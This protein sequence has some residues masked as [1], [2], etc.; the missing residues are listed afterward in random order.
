MMCLS[1]SE[2]IL[3]IQDHDPEALSSLQGRLQTKRFPPNFRNR[4]LSTESADCSWLQFIGCFNRIPRKKE[5]CLGRK[6]LCLGTKKPKEGVHRYVEA[7]GA[8][9][10]RC[11][12]D[13]SEGSTNEPKIASGVRRSTGGQ[14]SNIGGRINNIG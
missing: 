13:S 6:E 1:W 7:H 4:E 8:P 2:E 14:K 9:G 3:Y 11:E 10:R 12:V 5:P